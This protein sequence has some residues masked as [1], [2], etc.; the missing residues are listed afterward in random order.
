MRKSSRESIRR[1]VK[2]AK[3]SRQFQD[4]VGWEAAFTALRTGALDGKKG[5]L[6]GQTRS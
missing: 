2:D 3:A 4:L 1:G 5:I 6:L